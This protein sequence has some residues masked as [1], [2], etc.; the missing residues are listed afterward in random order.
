MAVEVDWANAAAP[1]VSPTTAWEQARQCSAGERSLGNFL[2]PL[3]LE[4]EGLV[5]PLRYGFPRHF[6]LG[7]LLRADL[8]ELAAAWVETRAMQLAGLY[9][10]V[11]QEISQS[12][13]PLVNLYERLSS[14]AAAIPPAV[15]KETGLDALAGP[16]VFASTIGKSWPD[17]GT[18]IRDTRA[19]DFI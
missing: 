6:A 8:K 2:S 3:V 10:R 18:D 17:Y 11:L 7:S 15:G 19:F 12:A 16:A 1:P 14:A 5:V 13:W 4:G 9:S